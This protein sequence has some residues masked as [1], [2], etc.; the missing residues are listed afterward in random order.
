MN[1]PGHLSP[2]E[3]LV[4]LVLA[5]LGSGALGAWL[6][7]MWNDWNVRKAKADAL[8]IEQNRHDRE[9]KKKERDDLILELKALLA[10]ERKNREVEKQTERSNY[11]ILNDRIEELQD[12]VDKVQSKYEGSLLEISRLNTEITRLKGS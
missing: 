1:E 11:G 8:Q 3:A 2:W 7:S 10:A 9:D 5:S 12:Q 6:K 4:G